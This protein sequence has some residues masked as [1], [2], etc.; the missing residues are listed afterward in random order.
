[1]V[2]TRVAS[3]YAKSLID[4]AVEKKILKEVYQDMVFFM[5]TSKSNRDFVL[6]LRNPIITHEKK[7]AVLYALFKD[8][9]NP[10]TLALFD[11]ITRKNRESYLPAIAESFEIQYRQHQGIVKATVTTPMPLTD[12]LKKKFIELVATQTG[13]KIELEEKVDPSI[14]GGYVLKIGDQ[15]MDNSIIAKLKTLSYEFSDDSYVKAI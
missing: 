9:F 1:M 7:K 11:I 2:N 12:T 13:K 14:I 6:M 3:R 5:E 4:L 8:K 15:Q 10:A